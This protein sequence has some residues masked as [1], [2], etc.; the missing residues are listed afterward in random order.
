[1]L[2]APMPMADTE[3]SESDNGTL[4]DASDA[5][6][7]RQGSI[8]G[9]DTEPVVTPKTEHERFPEPIIVTPDS[10]AP[11]GSQYS[12]NL[13]GDERDTLPPPPI[14]GPS[15]FS[16]PTSD[17][18]SRSGTGEW[19]QSFLRYLLPSSYLLIEETVTQKKHSK[20]CAYS[21]PGQVLVLTRI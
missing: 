3:Y 6:T 12:V 19:Y 13:L 20:L 11:G 14:P 2:K 15:L 16:A 5:E 10:R 9:D 17:Y 18:S 8:S 21:L 4:D 7:E 1:M